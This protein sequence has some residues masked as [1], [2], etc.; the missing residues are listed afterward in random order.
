MSAPPA[1]RF[2]RIRALVGDE[3]LAALARAHVAVVGLGAVGS[4][5]VEALARAGVGKLRLV[6]FDDIRPSNVNRQLFALESTLGR[7]KV[8]VA[9]ERVLDINPHCAVEALPL[10]AHVETMDRILAGPPGL[11]IDAIDSVTPKVELLAAA[12]ARGIPVISA[13]GAAVRTD[14]TQIRVG[15]LDESERCPLAR[16]VRR[17]LRRRG[18]PIDFL[19]VYS[20]EPV[21]SLAE[22]AGHADPAAE[23]PA[24]VRGRAR[25]PLGSLP[26]VTAI[27]G[28]VAANTALALLLGDR[29]PGRARHHHR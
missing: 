11:L 24:L 29:W 5:A 7:R 9:R 10:F 17:N 16:H 25:A 23:E 14:P 26:T 4:Y 21:G 27:F 22:E 19:C 3:G 8:D 6:D 20:T 13:M 12:G 28:L 15:P 1:E 2:A 18:A